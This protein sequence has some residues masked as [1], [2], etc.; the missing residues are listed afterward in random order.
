VGW[1][2]RAP[3]LRK[4]RHRWERRFTPAELD[5]VGAALGIGAV[6][7]LQVTLRGVS[8]RARSLVVDGARGRSV[9]E[10]E[11]QIRRLL[12]NLPSAMFVVDREPGALVLRG[13]GWGHGVGMCQ[14]GAIARAAAGQDHRA[15]LRAYYS[16]AEVAKIY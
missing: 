1:C 12:R 4:D 14:W 13:G 2:G 16:G 15:I 10:G 8:G 5:A 6:R 9:V 3:G 7:D 11:L